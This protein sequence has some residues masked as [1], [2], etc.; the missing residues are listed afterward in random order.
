MIGEMRDAET[1]RIALDAALSGH[2]IITTYHAGDVA[3]VFARM[4][5]Q[6]AGSF[7]VA[8]AVSGVF[9]QRLLTGKDTGKRRAIAAGFLPDDAWC[10]FLTTH[11]GLSQIRNYLQEKH[12]ESVLTEEGGNVERK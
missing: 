5:H 9:T 11:P 12:P 10:D 6:G 4:L 7:L 8:G 3:S 2:R 1:V